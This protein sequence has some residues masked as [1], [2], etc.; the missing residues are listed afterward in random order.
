MERTERFYRMIRMLR[1]SRIVTKSSFLSTLE[2]SRAQFTKDLAYL[3]DRMDAPIAFDKERG[4]YRLTG[5]DYELPGLWFNPSEIHALLTMH[6]LLEQVEPGMLGRH[7]APL[8]K[9]L[10]KLLGVPKG[11]VK[12][13]RRRIRI[14]QMAHRA[15]NLAHFELVAMAVLQRR[16]L[17]VTHFNRQHNARTSRQLSPQRLVHYRDNWYLDA[18]CHSRAALRSFSVDAIE[19]AE[20]LDTNAK[21]IADSELD[22]V[23]T[24]GYGIFSGAD[25]KHARLKF[26]AERARWVSRE[27]W[28]PQQ[29]CEF[30]PDGSYILELPYSDDRELIMD[31]LKYGPDI[32]V[33]GPPELREKTALLHRMAASTYT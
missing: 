19:E 32:E 7:I 14:L 2:I 30:D 28:H 16:R 20:M 26:T 10:E 23:L 15:H 11:P 5:D 9:R 31:I 18:W 24:A 33:I 8:Q 4:G 29:K 17:Q 3:R 6:H 25:V 13:V 12:Q 21:S 27:E 22:R 1:N